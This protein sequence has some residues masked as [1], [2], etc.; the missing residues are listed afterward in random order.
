VRS[1]GARNVHI[2]RQAV[3][4][5]FWRSRSNAQSTRTQP[6]EVAYIGRLEP[7][8]GVAVL[9]ASW[10]RL[11]LPDTQARLTLIGDGSLRHSNSFKTN[12][13]NMVGPLKT[14][15]EV[16]NFLGSTDVL[17]MPSI[18]TKSFREPWG[19]AINEAMNQKVAVIA[20]DAVGATAGGLVRHG[21]SGLVVPAR[22]IDHMANAINR[23][24]HEP[25]LRASLAQAGYKLIGAYTFAA[26]TE[27]FSQALAEIKGC[28]T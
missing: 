28:R 11:A 5:Q 2:A 10:H 7:E 27:G 21:S 25:N 6:Y 24:C 20:T 13:I 26:W 17:V 18:P 9:L 4:N 14:A 22:N 3:D 15:E 1:H 23:L 16:R 8:K 19:L 12:N